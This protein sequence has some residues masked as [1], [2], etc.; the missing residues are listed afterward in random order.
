MV[1][2]P[3]AKR[4]YNKNSTTAGNLGFFITDGLLPLQRTLLPKLLWEGLSGRV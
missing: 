2:L 3:F 4:S 1:S